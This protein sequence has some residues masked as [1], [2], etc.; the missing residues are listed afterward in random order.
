VKFIIIAERLKVLA[1]SH[2]GK[3]ML[4]VFQWQIMVYCEFTSEGPTTKEERYEKMLDCLQEDIHLK[5]RKMEAAQRLGN[6]MNLHENVPVHISQNSCSSISLIMIPW[7][8][9]I[10]Y[11]L[12]KQRH[13]KAS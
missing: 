8:S 3:V 7:C 4:K 12:P 11:I 2:K 10:H 6:P 13:L 5:H 1:G 9:L